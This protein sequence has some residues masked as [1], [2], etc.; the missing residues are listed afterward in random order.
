[1]TIEITRPET[2]ARI[3]RFLQAANSTTSM[4]CSAR[5]SMPCPNRGAGDATGKPAR[6]FM[7]SPLR[8]ANLNLK[9]TEDSHRKISPDRSNRERF[10]SGRLVPAITSASTGQIFP[11]WRLRMYIPAGR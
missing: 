1:M 11:W 4:S 10:R 3:Q 9:R 6:V 8:G 7:N 2:E 5:R